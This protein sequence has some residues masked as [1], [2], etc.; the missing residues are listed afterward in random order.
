MKIVSRLGV[1]VN[2]TLAVNAPG[3]VSVSLNVELPLV[4]A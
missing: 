2:P 4:T 3:Q 1:A